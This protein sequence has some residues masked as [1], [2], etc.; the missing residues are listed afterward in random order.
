M[1]NNHKGGVNGFSKYGD[2]CNRTCRGRRG[3]LGDTLRA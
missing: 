3:D 2:W 1:N